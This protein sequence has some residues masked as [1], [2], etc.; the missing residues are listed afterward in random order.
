MSI[1]K[2]LERLESG[3][4]GAGCPE[5]RDWPDWLAADRKPDGSHTIPYPRAC[6]RCGRSYRPKVYLRDEAGECV[7]DAV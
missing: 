6:P 7:M 2:R 5:C 1:I 3:R 4:W